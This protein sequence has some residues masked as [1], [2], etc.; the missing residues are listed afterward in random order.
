MVGPPT[1]P[2]SD[3][4]YL[5]YGLRSINTIS[6]RNS[7]LENEENFWIQS[8]YNQIISLSLSVSGTDY[9]VTAWDPAKHAYHDPNFGLDPTKY[10][11]GL[12]HKEYFYEWHYKSYQ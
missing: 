7:Q 9:I 11:H 4:G 12:S 10:G 3:Y 8:A 6:A 2:V 1:T 5:C